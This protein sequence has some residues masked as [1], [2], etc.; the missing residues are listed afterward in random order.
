MGPDIA[1]CHGAEMTISS[2]HDAPSAGAPTRSMQDIIALRDRYQE[3]LRQHRFYHWVRDPSVPLEQKLAF[4]PAMTLFVMNFRDMN[5]WVIR[6]AEARDTLE[7][8]INGST[9]EDETHSRLFLEDWRKLHFDDQL[10]WRA[11]D[12]L[13]WLFLSEDMEAFRRTAVEFMRLSVDDGG[14]PLVRFA[15]TEAGEACG[16]VFFEHISPLAHALGQQRGLEYRYFGLF[17]LA[18]ETGHVLDSEDVFHT[19]PLTDAQY[20][21][22]AALAKRM[23]AVFDV[24]HDAFIGYVDRYVATATTPRHALEV[25]YVSPD[26]D[27]RSPAAAPSAGFDEVHPSQRALEAHLQAR[28]AASAAHPFYDW[29]RE[30]PLPA[31]QKLQRFVPL[32]AFD[33]L[34]YRDLNRY[35]FRYDAPAGDLERSVN[36]VAAN[37]ETHSQLFLQD[38]LQL[39]LDDMLRWTA[40]DTLQFLFL[41]YFMDR[42]RHT[43]IRF[44]MLGLTH[45]GAL[46]RLWLMEAL[47]K[48]GHAF[49]EATRAVA[50]E[51]ERAHGLRLDYLC[52][53]HATVHPRAS[54]RAVNFKA[55]ALEGEQHALCRGFIDT[56]FDA[57]DANLSL[58]LD[59]AKSNKLAIRG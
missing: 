47:E 57:L 17:H 59:A 43:L 25:R 44:G 22:G 1:S 37:L 34:G 23:F 28:A 56:V 29:L 11:S 21:R 42:H 49:F 52:D 13:W 50:L 24:I 3:R 48:S 4:I 27:A 41:D 58:S 46:E 10:S 14:D 32:W 20:E 5:L 6:F 19:Q 35:V 9:I 53:R 33:M 36:A 55:V 18:L 8:I 30:A 7:E 12:V 45:R 54:G 51:A 2:A 40:S 15:H 38:W 39:G 16:H 31:L 26:E